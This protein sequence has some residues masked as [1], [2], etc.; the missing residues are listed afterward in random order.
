MDPIVVAMIHP[1]MHCS[2]D[3]VFYDQWVDVGGILSCH[4]DE[5]TVFEKERNDLLFR[6]DSVHAALEF[7][8][9][10]VTSIIHVITSTFY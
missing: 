5:S 3:T 9:Y 1:V 8:K 7:S 4:W 6:V 2:L 10:T